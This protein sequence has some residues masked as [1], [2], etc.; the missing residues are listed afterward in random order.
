MRL[1]VRLGAFIFCSVV[2]GLPASVLDPS[3]G[4]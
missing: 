4:S 3:I 2:S 1:G